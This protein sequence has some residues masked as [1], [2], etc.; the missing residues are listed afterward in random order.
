MEFKPGDIIEAVQTSYSSLGYSAR[1]T[2]G[3]HYIVR[4]YKKR[5]VITVQDDVGSKF[6]GGSA[7]NFILIGH[8]RLAAAIYGL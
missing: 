1:Y 8:S 5:H 3:T 6:N 2:R 7:Q 4:S